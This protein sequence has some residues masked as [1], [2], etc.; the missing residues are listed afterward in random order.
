MILPS[1]LE[2]SEQELVKKLETIK[3]DLI[4][5]KRFTS[6]LDSNQIHLHLDFVLEN[7]AK[8][9]KVMKSLG[10]EFFFKILLE[11]FQDFKLV[12]SVHLMGD[13]QDLFESYNFLEKYTANPNWQYFIFVPEKFTKQFETL[14]LKNPNF[15]IGIW[16]DLGDWSVQ[17]IEKNPIENYLLMTVLAGKSGQKLTTETKQIALDLA[18]SL[19][20]KNF[21]LDGGWQLEDQKETTLT[22][23]N[24]VSYSSFWNSFIT[25]Y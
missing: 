7:F 19:K 11:H 17:K 5:F 20:T 9:R 22:N 21:I 8:D 13:T 2:Y 23:L 14:K 16:Y 3:K 15:K 10:L 12:L 1:L 6:Q 18:T 4:D 24:M 25:Q